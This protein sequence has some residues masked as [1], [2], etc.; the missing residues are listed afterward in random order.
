MTYYL[1]KRGIGIIADTLA[2]KIKNNF[3]EA[4]IYNRIYVAIL[5]AFGVKYTAN[6]FRYSDGEKNMNG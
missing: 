3:Q 6:V 1:F 4:E 2:E 5:S